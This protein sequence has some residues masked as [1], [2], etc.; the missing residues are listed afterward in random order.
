MSAIQ[1]AR[2]RS[3]QQPGTDVPPDMMVVVSKEGKLLF[4]ATGC[5]FIRDKAHLRTTAAREALK[6]GYA[7]CA[8]WM[9]KYL[10]TEF[11]D[12]SFPFGGAHDP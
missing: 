3:R 12:S 2:K 6:E 8:R 1:E 5:P 10:Q 4:H 9:R 11:A 7:A